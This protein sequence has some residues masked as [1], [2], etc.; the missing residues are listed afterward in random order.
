MGNVKIFR[1]VAKLKNVEMFY[2]D[3]RI[4]AQVIVCLHGKY[5]RAETWHDFIREYGDKYRIIA[6]D[7]R[8][9]GL[10][11]K[12]LAEYTYE[13]MAEDI[14]EL[15]NFLEI[16][17]VIIV[18]H[19]M[20]GAVAGNLAALYPKHVSAAAIMDMSAAGSKTSNK[21][22]TEG[23]E[24]VDFFTKDW[25]LPFA[26]LN[27]AMNFIKKATGSDFEYQ[28]FMNSLIETVD[29]Y[30][31][32]F[33]RK[34][35]ALIGKNKKE[36]FNLLS[37]IKCPTILIRSSSHEAVPDEEF[38]KMQNLIPNC[39]SYEVS[40]PDHNVHL[41]NKEEFYRCFDKFLEGLKIF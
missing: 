39:I 23:E 4:E 24:L 34:A 5:G 13:E 41:A 36:W 17:S 22:I 14:I 11:S 12:P 40:H 9:H 33:S 2:L 6:P 30:G 1:S 16:D 37:S 38:I 7:Q 10:S 31:M 21:V 20:G 35:M 32:L 29:G 8:G 28:Y 15:L 26:T 27:E 18:G 25:P 19:S 3:T